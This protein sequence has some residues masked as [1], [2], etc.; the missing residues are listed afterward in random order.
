MFRCNLELSADV[1]TDEIL[2]KLLILI[3]NQIVEPYTG[4]D[5]YLLDA[6][7]G[8][9]TAKNA[10]IF[11]VIDDEVFA[12]LGRQTFSALAHT[13]F[14]LSLAGGLTEVR[15]RSADVVDVSHKI[16]DRKSVV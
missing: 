12:R 7:N 15:R 5:E 4:A 8:A 3:K 14:F 11:A 1:I 13:P 6:G 10:K 16:G 9:H 2:E